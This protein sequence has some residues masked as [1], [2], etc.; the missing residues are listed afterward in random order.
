MIDPRELPFI[1][2]LTCV[3]DG[4]FG[5]GCQY[6]LEACTFRPSAGHNNEEEKICYLLVSDED[7][8]K[9]TNDAIGER[10]ENNVNDFINYLSQQQYYA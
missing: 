10:F 4:D 2:A 8:A 6:G 5:Q 1:A 7:L 3:C 9:K